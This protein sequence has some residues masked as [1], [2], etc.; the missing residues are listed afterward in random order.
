LI[1]ELRQRI[2]VPVAAQVSAFG[3]I[4]GKK[5]LVLIRP[6]VAGFD[7]TADIDTVHAMNLPA[8]LLPACTPSPDSRNRLVKHMV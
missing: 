4:S 5:W 6:L 3:P 2:N 8:L 1:F 7:S